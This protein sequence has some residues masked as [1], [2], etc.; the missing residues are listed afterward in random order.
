M[1]PTLSPPPRPCSPLTF[2]PP[3]SPLNSQALKHLISPSPPHGGGN[4]SSLQSSH[5]GSF[6]SDPA[7]APP[8]SLKVMFIQIAHLSRT[9]QLLV[10]TSGI[11]A[12]LL[13]YG[14][15]QVRKALHRDRQ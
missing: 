1:S 2:L 11:F 14:F 13:I 4:Q 7:N 12:F 8:A 5:R 9:G 10:M 6:S 15:L 3:S